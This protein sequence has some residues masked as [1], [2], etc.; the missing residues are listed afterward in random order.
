MGAAAVE[1]ESLTGW[2]VLGI[3]IGHP[4]P[5]TA[6]SSIVKHVNLSLNHTT[7]CDIALLVC[8]HSTN[9]FIYLFID[10]HGVNSEIVFHMGAK[11][12]F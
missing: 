10:T 8:R 2:W 5:S 11:T 9:I 7:Q 12:P 6:A 1:V 3:G 4:Q